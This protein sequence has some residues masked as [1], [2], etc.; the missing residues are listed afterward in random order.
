M[1]TRWISTLSA[2]GIVTMTFATV[3]SAQQQAPPTPAAEMAQIAYFEG[4][5]TC[6]GKMMESPMGPAANT[7]TNVQIRKDLN[8]HFQTGVIKGS[9]PNLPPFEGRYQATYDA[10][11][12]QF[13]MMW[14]DNMGGWSQTSSPGWQGDTITYTGESHMG[15]QTMKTREVFTKSG[16]ASMKHLSEGE[17]NGKWMTLG[18]ETCN[19]K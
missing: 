19:K 9:A 18:D 13:V 16:A 1:R 6:S 10:G 17:M 4:T 14:A 11:Q 3:T 2:L 8:G 7:T 12:K 5:W 15:G